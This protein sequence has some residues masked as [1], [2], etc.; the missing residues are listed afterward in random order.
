MANPVLIIYLIIQMLSNNKPLYLCS[1]PK[2][3]F[4]KYA[5]HNKNGI[6][7]LIEVIDI[8]T[9]NLNLDPNRLYKPIPIQYY[10]AE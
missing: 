5:K 6:A 9:I 3:T 7:S 1:K 8:K 10:E 4:L 2:E